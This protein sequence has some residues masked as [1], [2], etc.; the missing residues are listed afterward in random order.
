MKFKSIIILLLLA[1]GFSPTVKGQSTALQP[2]EGA[3][4]TYQWNGLQSGDDYEFYLTA[5]A[6]G[7]VILDDGASGEFDFIGSRG[8]KVANG[9]SSASVPIKWNLGSSLHAYYLWFKVTAPGGCSN[10]SYVGVQPQI[11]RFDLLS[12]NVP[13]DNTVSCPAVA[14]SDGFNPMASA[15]DAGTT[16]LK[17]VVRRVNGTDNKLTAS[18]GDTYDWFFEPVLTVDPASNRAVSIVSIVG[19]KSGTLSANANNLYTVN[20]SDNEVIVTVAVKNVPGTSQDVKLNIRNQGELK[21][22]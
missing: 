4:H 19:S 16:T 3:T 15:Y 2:F 1:V 13:A 14:A 7:Q 17:F 10:Y 18:A 21:T 9:Q 20:G 11:N 22:N 12:E 6:S 8:G 5:D